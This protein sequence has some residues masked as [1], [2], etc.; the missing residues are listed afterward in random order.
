MFNVCLSHI[1]FAK[2]RYS[3]KS[4][5]YLL[6]RQIVDIFDVQVKNFNVVAKD[7]GHLI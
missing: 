7:T 5:E 4:F 2:E 1:R 6:D 3:I